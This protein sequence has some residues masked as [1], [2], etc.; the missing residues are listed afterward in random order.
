MFEPS[1]VTTLDHAETLNA[2]LNVLLDTGDIDE[3]RS[4]RRVLFSRKLHYLHS[5]LTKDSARPVV[6]QNEDANGFETWRRLFQKFA[7]PSAT[8][9]TAFADTAVGL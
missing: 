7:L 4:A 9:S 2:S 8:R 1:A 3:D 6:R 5:Q